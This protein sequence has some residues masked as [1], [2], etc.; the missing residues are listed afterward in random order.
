MRGT[1]LKVVGGV[2][3]AAVVCGV[4][5]LAGTAAAADFSETKSFSTDSLTVTNLIGEVRVTGHKGS[6]FEVVVDVQGDDASR[7]EV[8]VETDHD[9]LTVVFPK[10]KRYVY[11]ELDAHDEIT[12]RPNDNDSWIGALLGSQVKV[13]RSG[14]GL[15]IWADVEI[16]VPE[17]GRLK[18]RHGAGAVVAE[19][20]A[21]DLDLDSHHG[22]VSVVSVD[23]DLRVDTGSGNV[24]VVEVRGVINIDTGSG[25]VDVSAVQGDEVVI[26]TGS[27][28]VTLADVA[29]TN[30]VLIETGSGDIS[31]TEVSGDRFNI[32]TGSGDI[33]AR[34]VRAESAMIDTGSGAVGFSLAEMGR[35]DFDIDTGSGGIT[36][37]LPATAACEV[38]AEAGSGGVQVDLTGV[39]NLR[40]EDDDEVEFTLGDGG[41][42]VTLETGSGGIR[43][44]ESN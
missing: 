12:F 1:I 33:D 27:G 15:E 44:V 34:G 18:L 22:K 19:D 13:S 4:A 29:A 23:G 21:G 7:D 32:D 36:L 20:V 14:S 6:G 11:P 26:D 17:G 25:D 16:R 39:R 42:R 30:D 35:G 5:L 40:R 31:L 9:S 43:I 28:D 10:T 3:C 38:Q 41:A 8:Q 24:S 37:A 2:L